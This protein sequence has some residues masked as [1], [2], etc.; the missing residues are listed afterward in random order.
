[1]IGTGVCNRLL[2][3]KDQQRLDW[4]CVTFHVYY[5]KASCFPS[6]C[7]YSY[8]LVCQDDDLYPPSYWRAPEIPP[9]CSVPP[10]K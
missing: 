5:I 1:M 9:L 7:F 10:A 2:R 8:L 3:R 4:A 6:I